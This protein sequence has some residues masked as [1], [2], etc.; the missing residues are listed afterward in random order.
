[1]LRGQN[2]IKPD[3]FQPV[4][5]TANV[6]ATQGVHKVILYYG[7]GLIGKFTRVEMFDDGNHNDG[8][9]GDGIYGAQIPAHA[10]NQWVRFYIEAL[11]NDTWKTAKYE[12]QG[13]E[14]DVYIYQVKPGQILDSPPSGSTSLCRTMFL[15]LLILPVN[16]MIG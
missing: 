6:T 1:M 15:L 5:I 2:F 14:H 7:T 3:P 8:V 16:M 10:S 12:P 9:A 13:A 11:A 4:D